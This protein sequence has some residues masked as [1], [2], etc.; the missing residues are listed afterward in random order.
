MKALSPPRRLAVAVSGGR[1]SVALLL[2][3]AAYARQNGSEITAYTV[4]HGLR[5]ASAGEASRVGGWCEPFGIKHVILLWKGEK[6]NTGVQAAARE[7]RYSLLIEAAQADGCEALLTAHTADDQAET[8]FMRLARGAGVAGL[9]AIPKE[10]FFAAGA[11]EPLRV[12]RPLLE[13]TRKD[14]T[15]FLEKQGQSFVDDPSN[16]DPAFERVRVRALLAALEEQ[17]FVSIEKLCMTADK[18]ALA[19]AVLC[20]QEDSLFDALGGCFHSWGG[21]SVSDWQAG[22]A[23]SGLARRIIHAVGGGEY[24]P[25]EDKAAAAVFQAA[26]TGSATLAGALVK[27]WNGRLWFFREPS[28]LTG[29]E[30]VPALSPAP[31]TK[32]RVW[33][34]RFIVERQ[35]ATSIAVGPMGEMA[36]EFLGPR[37]GLFQGPREALSSL[38]GIYAAGKLIGAPALPFM[39][40]S[41]ASA[42]CLVTER[43]QGGIVRF[44]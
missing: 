41:A 40:R 1:D 6:P 4:D 12:L 25:G 39:G 3:C 2:L 14:V 18:L 34:R 21:V 17:E 16:D 36:A 20:A 13:F 28:A 38:P 44:S 19:D 26:N 43:Y 24:P 30:G 29:R 5:P 10:S 23:A 8:V 37:T 7:A 15:S 31:V 42:R 11:G 32:P 22:R 35:S 27:K 33:D 9:S